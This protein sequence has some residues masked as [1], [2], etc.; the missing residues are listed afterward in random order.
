MRE[1]L[2]YFSSAQFKR[3][4]LWIACTTKHHAALS[5]TSHV[6][7]SSLP[8]KC[9]LLNHH[10]IFAGLS[11]LARVLVVMYCGHLPLYREAAKYTREGHTAEA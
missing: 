9:L 6:K 10:W 4:D 2:K 11:L 8:Y 3:R 1:W 5:L 7:R